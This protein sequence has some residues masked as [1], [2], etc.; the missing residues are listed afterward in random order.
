MLGTLFGEKSLGE[1][2]DWKTDF[3]QFSLSPQ[4]QSPHHAPFESQIP[5]GGLEIQI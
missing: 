3:Q 4:H 2:N 5:D 1:I